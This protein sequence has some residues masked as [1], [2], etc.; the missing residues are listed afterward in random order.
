MKRLLKILIGCTLSVFII[1]GFIKQP[2][3]TQSVDKQVTQSVNKQV[4]K[5]VNQNT[6]VTTSAP[7]VINCGQLLYPEADISISYTSQR[8]DHH[9]K[10][11][12]I[13]SV[14]TLGTFIFPTKKCTLALIQTYPRDYHSKYP[15][16]YKNQIVQYANTNMKTFKDALA[17]QEKVCTFIEKNLTSEERHSFA[18]TFKIFYMQYKG[19]KEFGDLAYRKNEGTY[20][21]N[22]GTLIY[23][24]DKPHEVIMI[25]NDVDA[26]LNDY[27]LW[28]NAPK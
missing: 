25:P 7:E 12:W 18:E 16:K 13:E 17:V 26:L 23:N 3:T 28:L 10:D 11:N 9:L 19:V 6:K 22:D 14:D 5:S 24:R 20:T 4:T 15:T 1:H 2:T 21:Q 27:Y 8:I